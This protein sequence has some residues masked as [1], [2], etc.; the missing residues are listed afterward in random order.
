MKNKALSLLIMSLLITGCSLGGNKDS[1]AVVMKVKDAGVDNSKE[2]KDS[3]KDTQK[4]IDSNNTEIVSDTKENTEHV[5]VK[6]ANK[7]KDIKS[8][9]IVLDTK[10][11]SNVENTSSN[12]DTVEN[13]DNEDINREDEAIDIEVEEATEKGYWFNKKTGKSLMLGD[14]GEY[15]E[16]GE[17]G[18]IQ[19]TYSIKN[20]KIN[21]KIKDNIGTDKNSSKQ[22]IDRAR[23]NRD[24]EYLSEVA[25]KIK[26]VE[27]DNSKYKKIVRIS[28]KKTKTKNKKTELKI[29]RYAIGYDK[30]GNEIGKVEV[31]AGAKLESQYDKNSNKKN[32]KDIEVSYDIKLNKGTLV[33]NGAEYTR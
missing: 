13:K 31:K 11:S 30:N 28:K 10:D 2:K 9:D 5:S 18:F 32:K 7:S 26:Y 22:G 27:E 33:I 29:K 1:G 19:G 20:G 3:I 4:N 21:I 8:K 17:T 12:D 16:E 15:V 25:D 24:L 23:A 6:A 14:N